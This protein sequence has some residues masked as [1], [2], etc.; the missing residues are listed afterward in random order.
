VEKKAI[1]MFAAICGV[2]SIFAFGIRLVNVNERNEAAEAARQGV[3]SYHSGVP[4]CAN[5]YRYEGSRRAWL[6]GWIDAKA[7]EQNR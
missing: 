6:Q 5:P 3:Q 4:A 2:L 7:S 1:G